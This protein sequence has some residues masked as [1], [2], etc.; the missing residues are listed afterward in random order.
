M[1]TR[2]I[3]TI[4]TRRITYVKS[5]CLCQINQFSLDEWF[6]ENYNTER[7][8]LSSQS[9][10]VNVKLKCFYAFPGYARVYFWPSPSWQ[11]HRKG[12]GRRLRL[13]L[14]EK[15]TN[16][17]AST[18]SSRWRAEYSIVLKG[19]PNTMGKFLISKAIFW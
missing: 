17:F 19:A 12:T 5:I 9:M 3:F 11:Q 13:K 15:I 2:N 4:N 10:S 16:V 7:N 18:T 8:V 14:L 1:Y 6:T